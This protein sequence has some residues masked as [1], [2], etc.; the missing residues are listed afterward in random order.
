M[1]GKNVQWL[2]TQCT[3]TTLALHTQT[4]TCA[5]ILHSIA[6]AIMSHALRKI[7][8]TARRE[9]TEEERT[10]MLLMREHKMAYAEIGKTLGFSTS[11]IHHTIKRVR[12]RASLKDAKRT[13]QPKKIPKK[14]V[15]EMK[16]QLMCKC[17]SR[18]RRRSGSPPNAFGRHS[19]AKA[20]SH[21]IVSR[22]HFFHGAREVRVCAAMPQVG[23]D[24]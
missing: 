18:R 11:T 23:Q 21:I 17:G 20:F 4:T 22:N 19:R 5:V 2:P 3:Q 13:G 15:Q 10:K 16:I 24:G 9:A 1:A 12:E 7:R 8:K 6:L 14:I